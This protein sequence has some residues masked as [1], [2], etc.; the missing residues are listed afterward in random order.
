[1]SKKSMFGSIVLCIVIMSIVF[2]FDMVSLAND[3][4]QLAVWML[5]YSIPILFILFI[6]LLLIY[7]LSSRKNHTKVSL[8]N[9]DVDNELNKIS[10]IN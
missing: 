6:S 9:K 7:I 10:K 4:Y 8:E 3:G 2:V 1:M 5:I